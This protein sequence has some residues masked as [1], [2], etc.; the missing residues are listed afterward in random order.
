MYAPDLP[1]R[2]FVPGTFESPTKFNSTVRKLSE[3]M[4][5]VCVWTSLDSLKAW[6]SAREQPMPFFEVDTPIAIFGFLSSRGAIRHILV[7]PQPEE[8]PYSE[9][10][11]LD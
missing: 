6:L 3:G 10:F 8:N 7:D 2:L 11:P 9:S 4:F 1:A 5:L